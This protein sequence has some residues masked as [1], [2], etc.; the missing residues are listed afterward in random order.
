VWNKTHLLARLHT[1][2]GGKNNRGSPLE[3][4]SLYNSSEYISGP[5]NAFLEQGLHYPPTEGEV[6]NCRRSPVEAQKKARG[7]LG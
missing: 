3:S 1:R 7:A 6:S 2:A 5:Q 4:I